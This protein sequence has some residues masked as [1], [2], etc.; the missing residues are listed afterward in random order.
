VWD[1]LQVLG[2]GDQWA[3]QRPGA[4]ELTQALLALVL[5]GSGLH[6]AVGA[7]NPVDRADATGQGELPFQALGPA[8]GLTT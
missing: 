4:L 3:E 7:H 2:V 5:L 6:Q 1:V 8:A